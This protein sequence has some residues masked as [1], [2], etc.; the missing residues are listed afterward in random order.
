MAPRDRERFEPVFE[1]L[2]AGSDGYFGFSAVIA[3]VDYEERP[4]SYLCRAAVSRPG[5]TA[6]GGHVFIKIFKPKDPAQGV[7]MRARVVQDYATTCEIHSFMAPA[8]GLGA[9]RPIA[10]YDDLLTIVT[11]QAKGETLLEALQRRGTWFPGA[12]EVASLTASA[13]AIGRWLARFQEFKP[14]TGHVTITALIDYVDVR[15]K[16]LLEHAVITAGDRDRILAHLRALGERIAAPELREV[17]THADLAP[18]NVLISGED[19]VVLDFAMAG[20]A[21]SLHDVSRLY[22]Q[23]DLLRAKPQFRRAVLARLQAALLEGLDPSLTP[24]RPL[25]RLLS[26][27]HHV[28]HFGTVS[29]RRESFPARLLNWRVARMHRR[30]IDSELSGPQ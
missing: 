20:R 25:F 17:S 27:L 3:G 30:W 19:V 24:E 23:L 13:R 21:T 26:M 6:P 18:A 5:A 9:V 8:P 7:D 14:G 15:L 28:N 29:L 12:A 22:M 10:C 4:F 16:R 2:R 11:E 1:R